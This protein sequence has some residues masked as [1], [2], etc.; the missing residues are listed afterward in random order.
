MYLREKR[1]SFDEFAC[2]ER[3]S[4]MP[5]TAELFRRLDARPLPLF[6]K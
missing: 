4:I 2:R 6:K 5:A 1:H 3:T